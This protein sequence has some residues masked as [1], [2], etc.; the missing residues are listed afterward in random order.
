VPDLIVTRPNMSFIHVECLTDGLR[1]DIKE[2]FSCY[3][4]KY[5][6]HPKYQ[7][8]E[9]SNGSKFRPWNGKTSFYK[10]NI[11]DLPHGLL[12]MLEEFIRE[13]NITAEF[14]FKVQKN[15]FDDA[16]FEEFYECIFKSKDFYPRDYQHHA[17]K[18]LLN[19]KRGTIEYGTGAGK[20][21]IIYCLIRFLL[22]MKRRVCLIVPNIM[23]VEQ[24][25][26]EFIK[27]GWEDIDDFLTAQYYGNTPDIKKPVL[28]STF[29]S[30]VKM[31]DGIVESYT[32]VITD[33]TH[34]A[35]SE[36]IMN[37]L[38]RMTKADYRF[39]VTGTLPE[40]KED[41]I[42]DLLTIYGYIG[43]MV[44]RKPAS[45]L[46]EEGYL[47][48]MS[49][50]VIKIRHPEAWTK[51]LRYAEYEDEVDYLVN[52]K[53]RLEV[54][55]YII[56]NGH[57][58]GE[59]ILIL[60]ERLEHINLVHQYL[61]EKYPNFKVSLIHGKIKA[62]DRIKIQNEVKV[63]SN[64]IVVATFGT[65]AVGVDIPKID[66]VVLNSSYKSKTKVVQSIGRGLRK[67]DD[68]E[69]LIVWDLVDDMRWITKG[70]NEKMNCTYKQYLV[71]LEHYNNQ[72]Y[73]V[74]E[75]EIKLQNVEELT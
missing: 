70:G 23:L 29:Q 37:I 45:E 60:C 10:L 69:Q 35:K 9:R 41:T 14:R 58:D 33:E 39:G 64:N 49:V 24:M 31:E 27:Y 67:H 42:I 3:A 7:L 4:P 54:L 22:A 13:R 21:N 62:K 17:V 46:I 43:K 66:H 61:V 40:A 1:Y 47:S 59:N 56:S 51:S 25:K 75:H 15:T 11:R 18:M 53:P 30:L 72:K 12:Y 74:F 73:P 48:D 19:E 68:K 57:K 52:C 28:V 65:M 34:M 8:V 16:W 32:G 38:S 36:S 55:D 26:T 5:K 63:T 44:A 6:F 20:S 50:A 2:F 71:R